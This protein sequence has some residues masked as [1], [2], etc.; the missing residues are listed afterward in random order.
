MHERTRVLSE[1]NG[2]INSM[3]VFIGEAP[4]RLGADRTGVPFHGDQAGQRF[5]RLLGIAS[6]KRQDVFI[7]NA[8]LCNPRSEKGNNSAPTKQE[9]KNCSLYLSILLDI[10]QPELIVTL[11]QWA[12]NALHI[13][14]SHQIKLRDDV[15]KPV[16]W[17][18][19]TVLPMY[20]PGPR[21]AIHRSTSDQDK[22][23]AFLGEMLGR[24]GIEETLHLIPNM[25]KL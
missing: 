11:G 3:V 24:R 9:I 18:K 20:H 1:K 8:I 2:D 23:F 16:R 5:E 22:D 19:F 7:T 14:Q 12:L 21:S 10:I 25:G 6:L 13:I 15:R 17:S 4:G